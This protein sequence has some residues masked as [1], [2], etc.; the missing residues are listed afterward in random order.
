[1]QTRTQGSPEHPFV[2]EIEKLARA[3]KKARDTSRAES[4]RVLE[5]DEV[6]ART[7]RDSSSFAGEDNEM[8]L[9]NNNDNVGGG[10][11]AGDPIPGGAEEEREMLFGDF[12][13]PGPFE[14]RGAILLPTTNTA[15]VIHPQYVRMV[16]GEA[17]HGNL[18]ENPLLHLEIFLE[19]CSMIATSQVSQ[20]YIRL[21]LFRESLTDKAK[22][23]L[24]GL[25]PNSLT[26]WDEA[27]VHS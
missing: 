9:E 24:N 13:N 4:S 3:N 20:E 8:N 25:R 21:H 16:Q 5:D 7:Y 19:I 14:F 22:R 15:F 10:G 26:T 23:W 17:F 11:G 2:P 1:M 18:N 6:S 12:G 27:N